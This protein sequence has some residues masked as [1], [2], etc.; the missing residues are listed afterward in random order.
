MRPR[1]S[2]STLPIV[3]LVYVHLSTWKVGSASSIPCCI[4]I[5][6]CLAAGNKGAELLFQAT[7]EE[8]VRAYSKIPRH[9]PG[10]C[11]RLQLL[12]VH[13]DP[14]APSSRTK[15]SALE[16]CFPS[17]LRTTSELVL[18]TADFLTFSTDFRQFEQYL[19]VSGLDVCYTRL[20][21]SPLLDIHL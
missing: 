8:M 16:Y 7:S 1:I 12:M 5:G 17:T 3:L 13:P 20:S 19:N 21:L 18:E 11:P 15:Y 14:L 6:F 9:G 2:K 10:C 4:F